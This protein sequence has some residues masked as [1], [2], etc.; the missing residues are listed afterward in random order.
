MEL[1]DPIPVGQLPQHLAMGLD[2]ST[3]YVA[4][5]GGESIDIVDLDQQQVS[6]NIQFP[7]LPLAG[8]AAIT[9]VSGMAVGLSGLQLVMSN[10]DL[11]TV[12]N[13]QALPRTGTS[14][15]GVSSTGVQTPIA[16]PT[17][18][19]LASDDGTSILL[20]GG[21]GTA[22]LYSGLNDV[23]TAAEQLFTAPIIG[24][25]GPL[26][27]G[28]GG[29]FLLAD[30][31]VLDSS[32]AVIGGA[33]SPGQ[34]AVTPPAGPGA[35]PSTGVT[36]TGLRNIAA[37]AP[38]GQSGFVRMSTAVRTSLTATTS[39]NTHTELEAVDTQTGATATV[40]EMPENPVLSE[41]GTTRTAMTPRQMVVDPTSGTLYALTV[42]GLSVVPITPASAPQ[43]SS[44]ARITNSINGSGNFEPGSFIVINGSNL[45]SNATA[46]TLPPPV[47]LGGSCV[48]FDDVAIPLLST[49]ATQISAQ[50]PATV[51]PGENVVQ[52]RS[53]ANAQQSAR[54][55]VTLQEP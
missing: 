9:T 18:N 28:P 15:T 53:L 4:N 23:Y 37:V 21:T 45:A 52:V 27:L 5:T 38:V 54:V 41:F 51:R 22:Y 47:V 19:M 44:S 11:W 32:L 10:G 17:R 7:P 1:Q 33:A 35:P 48:L 29:S 14:I 8:N 20:L 16:A 40:A 49:S 30:G 13:N 55:V 46:N 3:L 31:L 25:Y 6:G 24:Y 26:G 2:G 36:S 34:V 12:V 42:S 39:D 43:I 50:I